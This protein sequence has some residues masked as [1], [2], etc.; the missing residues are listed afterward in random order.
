MQSK[1][2]PAQIERRFV[3]EKELESITGRSRKTWQ[4]DRLFSRG[5]PFYKVGGSILYDL[6]E[7]LSWIKSQRGGGAAA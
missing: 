4:K 3:N 7:V 2:A 5:A 6:Q 1:C